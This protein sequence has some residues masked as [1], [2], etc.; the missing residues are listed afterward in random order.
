MVLITL[1]FDAVFTIDIIIM[2][3]ST[4]IISCSPSFVKGG[5]CISLPIFFCKDTTLALVSIGYDTYFGGSSNKGLHRTGVIISVFQACKFTDIKT[6]ARFGCVIILRTCYQGQ[7]GILE[8]CWNH[9]TG[10]KNSIFKLKVHQPRILPCAIHVP[11]M[12]LHHLYAYNNIV[13]L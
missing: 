13:I 2:V 11:D 9:I 4:L 10:H 5:I 1:C 6:T 8:T 12:L 7:C 3:Y